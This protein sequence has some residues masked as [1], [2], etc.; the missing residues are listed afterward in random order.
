MELQ[1]QRTYVKNHVNRENYNLHPLNTPYVCSMKPVFEDLH[2]IIFT[3]TIIQSYL[4]D[5]GC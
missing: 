1:W 4:P 5:D 3:I 2:F